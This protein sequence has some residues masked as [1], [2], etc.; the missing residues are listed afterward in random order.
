MRGLQQ[1]ERLL[2]RVAQPAAKLSA[3]G[4]GLAPKHAEELP[5]ARGRVRD[6]DKAHRTD[7]GRG[8]VAVTA[9]RGA[10]TGC[11]AAERGDHVADFLRA[12]GAREEQARSE[13]RTM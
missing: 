10:R 7:C 13:C 12:N 9:A 4:A 3:G 11:A 6:A 5:E 8:R 1:A 2:Q